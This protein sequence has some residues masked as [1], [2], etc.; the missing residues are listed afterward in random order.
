MVVDIPFTRGNSPELPDVLCKL[1][2]EIIPGENVTILGRTGPVKDTLA[3]SFFHFIKPTKG[4][5][6]VDGLDI[7][8]IALSDLRSKVT[9]INPRWNPAIYTGCIRQA[10][11]YGNCGFA[12]LHQGFV[13][14]A[15]RR[16]HL[17]P[18]DAAS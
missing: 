11:K 6:T 7:S 16:V 13:L 17:I 10:R 12:F 15:L 14:E 2:F 1:N 9:I 3:L 4:S 18:S 8:T 5:I